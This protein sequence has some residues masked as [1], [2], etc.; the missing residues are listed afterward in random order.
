MRARY[1]PAC[2]RSEVDFRDQLLPLEWTIHDNSDQS[3]G[4]TS[5]SRIGLQRFASCLDF[6]YTG[7]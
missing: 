7:Y 1:F 3:L 2:F 4:Q 5:S 6:G